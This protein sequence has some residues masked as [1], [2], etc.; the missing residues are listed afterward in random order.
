MVPETFTSSLFMVNCSCRLLAAPFLPGSVADT[1]K[2]PR[3]FC[4]RGSKTKLVVTHARIG[5]R[6]TVTSSGSQAWRPASGAAPSAAAAAASAV[7]SASAGASVRLG[8]IISSTFEVD[9]ILKHLVAG[10]HDLGVR[11][12]RALRRDQ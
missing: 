4:N 1:G 10:R 7:T 6:M 11:L 2:I 3:P 8:A 12:E 5:I 9:Q